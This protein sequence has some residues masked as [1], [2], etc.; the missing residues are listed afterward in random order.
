M[1]GLM[2][3]QGAIGLFG[4][5]K[6]MI[7]SS[8]MAKQNKEMQERMAADF[9]KSNSAITAQFAASSGLSANTSGAVGQQQMGQG[10]FPGFMA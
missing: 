1:A 6:G 8:K 4:Q 2:V 9:A 7:D 10:S 3:A 5:V